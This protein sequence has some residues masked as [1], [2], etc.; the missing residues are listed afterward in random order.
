MMWQ[1][2]QSCRVSRLAAVSRRRLQSGPTPKDIP[3]FPLSEAIGYLR[4]AGRRGPEYPVMPG[5]AEYSW[6]PVCVTLFSIVIRLFPWIERA[7]A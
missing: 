2:C 5:A 1:I 6:P 4:R 7:T 3:L